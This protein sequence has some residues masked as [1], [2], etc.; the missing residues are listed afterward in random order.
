M[1]NGGGGVASR[2]YAS[3]ARTATNHVGPTP[4][5]QQKQQQH[6]HQHKQLYTLAPPV[7]AGSH[8][9]GKLGEN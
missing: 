2:P 8:L 4:Q 1:K 9:Y 7:V 5:L 6:Q 3:S